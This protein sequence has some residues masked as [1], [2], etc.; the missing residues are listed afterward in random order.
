V[1]LDHPPLDLKGRFP[2]DQ[3]LAIRQS[4]DSIRRSFD[5]FNER[6]VQ[7]KG[8]SS[9]PGELNH[10]NFLKPAMLSIDKPNDGLSF[11]LVFPLQVQ[12]QV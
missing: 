11:S 3:T 4:N 12:H 2:D 5:S 10:G 7:I 9:Q 6:R 1:E 8:L